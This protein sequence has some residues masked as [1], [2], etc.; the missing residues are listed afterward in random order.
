MRDD[1]LLDEAAGR[2]LRPYTASDGRTRPT[3]ELDLI[4]LVTA[5]DW[6]GRHAGADAWPRD[7]LPGPD[8][9]QVLRL[10][11]EPISVAEIAAHARLPIGVTKVLLS[12]L[13]ECGAVT[14]RPP[15]PAAGA[16]PHADRVLLEAVLHGLRN[17]L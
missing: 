14:V 17:R 7:G 11:R 15:V 6:P 13:L 16:H 1:P 3:A 12:D 9:A 5:T 8:H 2:L 4:T 10:C